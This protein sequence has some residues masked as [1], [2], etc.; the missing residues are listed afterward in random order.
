M[1]QILAPVIEEW[2]ARYGPQRAAARAFGPGLELERAEAERVLEVVE[3]AKPAR[4][5]LVRP[6]A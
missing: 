5:G 6:R 4:L 3:V 2:M 1:A